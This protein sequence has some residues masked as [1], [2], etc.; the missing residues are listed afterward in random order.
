MVEGVLEF[1]SHFYTVKPVGARMRVAL[2]EWLQGLT[3]EVNKEARQV[4]HD[5]ALCLRSEIR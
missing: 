5:P 3:K 4:P 1:Y 2:R